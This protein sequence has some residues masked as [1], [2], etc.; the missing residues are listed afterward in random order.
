VYD[1]ISEVP[2]SGKNASKRG[3][4]PHVTEY[5]GVKVVEM[6]ERV[7]LEL[8][9]ITRAIELRSKQL[10]RESGLTAP[11]L[12]VMRSISEAGAGL[13][14]GGVARS[15]N[16]SQA[17]V[18]AILDRL[19]RKGYLLRRRSELDKRR[20]EVTLSIAGMEALAE[21]PPL[22]QEEFVRAFGDL[23]EWEQTQILSSLQH[24]SEMMNAETLQVAPLLE[25]GEEEVV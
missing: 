12:M 14:V 21:A 1:I 19:E 4:A 24:L 3:V 15:V 2:E 25:F 18:T 17:T 6:H 5:I 16:L 10:A 20:V 23:K 22:L 11:Q 9:K 13:T 7:L 8:R